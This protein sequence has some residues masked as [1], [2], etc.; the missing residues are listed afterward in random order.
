MA[1]LEFTSEKFFSFWIILNGQEADL[2]VK[3]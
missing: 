1:I 3:L 2:V